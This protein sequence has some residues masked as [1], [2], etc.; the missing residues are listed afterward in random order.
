L[1]RSANAPGLVKKITAFMSD[2]FAPAELTTLDELVMALQMA[3]DASSVTSPRKAE[4]A[5]L[6]LTGITALASRK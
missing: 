1:H 4:I 6:V 2:P 3:L 5:I